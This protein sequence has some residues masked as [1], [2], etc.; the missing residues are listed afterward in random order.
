MTM[1]T[2]TDIVEK[3]TAMRQ[4]FGESLKT[5]RIE[6]RTRR[7]EEDRVGGANADGGY[8]G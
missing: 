5:V 1:T 6:D 2:R 7:T 8:S 3:M 4:E